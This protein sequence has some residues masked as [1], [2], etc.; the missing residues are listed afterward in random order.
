QGNLASNPL[1]DNINQAIVATTSLRPPPFYRNNPRTWFS[2]LEAQFALARISSQTTQFYHCLANLPE[3]VAVMIE[4]DDAKQYGNLKNAILQ[5]FEKSKTERLEEALGNLQLQGLRPSVAIQKLRRSFLAANL[6]ADDDLLK[7]RLIKAMPPPVQTA[8]AAQQHLPL[9]QFIPVADAV[10]DVTA[11]TSTTPVHAVA[12]RSFSPAAGRRSPS[13]HRMKPTR[14]FGFHPSALANANESAA[15]TF[16]TLRLLAHANPGARGLAENPI[17]LT[18]HRGQVHHN[19]IARTRK[20][21]RLW[22]SGDK[23]P[24]QP[25]TSRRSIASVS[26]S[27]FSV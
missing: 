6:T 2:Q 23:S 15:P 9:T 25:N 8:L 10:F 16:S 20:T 4:I 1:G 14:K 26:P 11:A 12:S 17:E 7:Y 18:D 21:I 5:A 13:P 19:T 3:D 22:N 24:Q 27:L